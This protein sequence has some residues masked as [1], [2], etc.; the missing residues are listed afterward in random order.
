M[1]KVEQMRSSLALRQFFDSMRDC[2]G[3]EILDLGEFSQANRDFIHSLG[4][5]LLND[6]IVARIDSVFGTGDPSAVQ[7]QPDLAHQFLSQSLQWDPG[8]FD[9]VFVWDTL[10]Y[11]SRPLLDAVIA[12]LPGPLDVPAVEGVD[13]KTEELVTRTA[14]DEE[15]FAALA[16]KIMADPFVG[17]LTY[18]RVY[19]GTL[20][21]GAR[22]L[23]V[24][25]GK[26]ERVGRILMMHANDREE[27]DRVYAGDI[28][29]AVGIKQIVT[30][31]HLIRP[32]GTVR[33]VV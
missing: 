3:L 1:T 10:Q 24:S 11:A 17:K 19:S 13:P 4:H 31:E 16:F 29:A 28:A 12:Y 30:G 25:S 23:N 15:P 22:I 27:L 33:S 5:R 8:Q 7:R 20:E 26:T 6:D 2:Q 32:D 14:S 21:S 18:F 9:A